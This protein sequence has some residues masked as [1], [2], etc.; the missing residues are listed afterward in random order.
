MREHVFTNWQD[1]VVY[2]TW[3]MVMMKFSI[4]QSIFI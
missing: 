1:C 3:K 4:D 2:D